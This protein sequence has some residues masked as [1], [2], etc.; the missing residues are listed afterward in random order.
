MVT[1]VALLPVLASSGPTDIGMAQTAT[2]EAGM[3][4]SPGLPGLADGA[5]ALP[6][7]ADEDEQVDDLTVERI[8]P[9]ALEADSTLTVDGTVTNTGDSALDSVTVRVRYSS[10]ALPTRTSL[11]EHADGDYP[12]L[13]RFG[14]DQSL[15]EELEP[16]DSTT[17]TL[18]VD[19][20][21]LDVSDFGVYPLVVEAVD[22]AGAPLGTQRTFL[23]YTDS[24]DV[25]PTELAWVWPLADQPH[26]AD[27]D[28]FLG[29]GLREQ[30]TPDGRLERLLT[31]GLSAD[32][33]ATIDTDNGVDAQDAESDDGVPLTWAIDPALLDDVARLTTSHQVLDDPAA[34]PAQ[35]EP[36]L[37]TQEPDPNAGSWL[38]RAQQGLAEASVVSSAYATPSIGSLLEADLDQDAE[39][40]HALGQQRITELLDRDIDTDRMWLPHGTADQATVDFFAEED[41]ATFVFDD[42]ALPAQDQVGHTPDATTT[43]PTSDDTEATAVVTD[44]QLGHVLDADADTAGQTMLAEQ[45]YIAETALISAERPDTTQ[46]VVAA[47]PANWNP[48]AD[49]ATG[50]LEATESLPWLDPVSLDELAAEPNDERQELGAPEDGPAELSD[51][52]LDQINDIR[53]EANLFGSVLTEDD[54]P[55]RP[56]ILRLESAA[57]EEGEGA[58]AGGARQRV[59]TALDEAIGSVRIMPG[60]PVTMASKSGEAPILVAND[61]PD[62]SVT[63]HLSVFSQNSERLSVGDYTDTMEIAP[64]GRTTVYVPLSASVNGRTDLEL[65]LHNADGEPISDEETTLPVTVTG[66]GTSALLIS[67]A[68]ALVLLALLVLRAVRRRR[69]GHADGEPARESTGGPTGNVHD[70]PEMRHNGDGAA[71]GSQPEPGDFE[72][73][74]RAEAPSNPDSPGAGPDNTPQ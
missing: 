1:A 56:A 32:P 36:G 71:E 2:T 47:P 30:L 73:Q 54:D 48:T 17:Y 41:T 55:F 52:Y 38:E 50:V 15:D 63:V 67:G 60:E 4:G 26:R 65:G 6:S 33:G 28:T 10:Q 5:A 68:A 25:E 7:G 53:A 3:S 44:H 40:S 9:A 66:L 16:G 35:D 22:D 31:L 57:W 46:T 58:L 59:A 24:D 69:G 70:A 12:E 42:S 37:V 21:D 64:G 74:T 14:V 8:S 11:A 29:D 61:L 39:A 20:A 72:G 27:D 62:H 51:A 13:Q 45:R 18:R 23:P 19:M 43:L 49:L 34:V